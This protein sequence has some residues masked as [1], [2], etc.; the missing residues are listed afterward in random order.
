MNSDHPWS[1]FFGQA[2][3][4][5]I[6]F[7]RIC[8]RACKD[9]FARSKIGRA[10]RARRA[11]AP[12][13][14]GARRDQRGFRTPQPPPSFAAK[15]GRSEPRVREGWLLISWGPANKASDRR[16]GAPD[17]CAAGDYLIPSARVPGGRC[18]LDALFCGAR[19]SPIRICLFRRL[20]W[21]CFPRRVGELAPAAFRSKAMQKMYQN[22]FAGRNPLPGRT[23]AVTP[24]LNGRAP[25]PY[26]HGVSKVCPLPR[27]TSPAVCGLTT[28]PGS[29]CRPSRD[30]SF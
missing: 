8:L 12:A 19:V 29:A 25:G 28:A 13:S 1:S 4:F 11:R 18:L 10:K 7:H 20:S 30:N 26:A 5:Q 23:E 2:A 24:G 14:R 27:L 15:I 21:P 9:N 3:P 16:R 6:R 22:G 17:S